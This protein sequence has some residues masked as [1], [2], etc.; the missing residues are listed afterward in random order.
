MSILQ[1]DFVT[2][3]RT[4]GMRRI[5]DPVENYMLS[6]PRPV[7]SLWVGQLRGSPVFG[8][9]LQGQFSNPQRTL[10]R[11]FVPLG[12]T[13]SRVAFSQRPSGGADHEP[14]TNPPGG[15]MEG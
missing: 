5:C 2:L 1:G 8:I 12:L 13:D 9:P 15:T 3:G 11:D 14:S 10:R 4:G 7:S 6:P